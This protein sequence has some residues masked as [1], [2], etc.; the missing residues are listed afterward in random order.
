[1]KKKII[2]R[3]KDALTL[4]LNVGKGDPSAGHMILKEGGRE[5]NGS[6]SKFFFGLKPVQWETGYSHSYAQ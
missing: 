4:I 6:R 3:R 2:M 1:M 5:K